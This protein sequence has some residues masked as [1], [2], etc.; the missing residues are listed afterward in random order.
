MV[1]REGKGAGP[2][3]SASS[4]AEHPRAQGIP[5]PHGTVQPF[6]T[7]SLLEKAF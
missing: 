1:M 4:G 3:G 6:Y 2:A 5:H 7:D